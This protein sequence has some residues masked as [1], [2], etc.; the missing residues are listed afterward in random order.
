MTV[1]E[2]LFHLGVMNEWDAAVRRRDRDVMIS[3]LEMAE[4]SEPRFT[5]DTVLSDPAKY[6]F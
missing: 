5:V 1:N 6:G 2:R 4:V 3:L